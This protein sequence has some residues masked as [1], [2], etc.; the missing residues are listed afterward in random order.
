MNDLRRHAVALERA[1]RTAPK[2]DEDWDD[3]LR[4]LLADE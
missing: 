3:Q 1:L 2:S 4:Q